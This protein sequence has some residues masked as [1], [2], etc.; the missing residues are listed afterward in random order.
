MLKHST[1]P[2]L[3]KVNVV[4]SVLV[5]LAKVVLARMKARYA[6]RAVGSLR[7]GTT[8]GA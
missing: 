3:D 2:K 1:P 5:I 6:G 4:R 7:W 8:K